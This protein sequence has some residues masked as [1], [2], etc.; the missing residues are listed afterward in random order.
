MR[1]YAVT[2]CPFSLLGRRIGGS[3]GYGR[4]PHGHEFLSRLRV[5]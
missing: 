1:V 4:A 5:S 3:G 2:A